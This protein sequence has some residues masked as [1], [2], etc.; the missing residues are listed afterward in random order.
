MKFKIIILA[1]FFSCSLYSQVYSDFVQLS[2]NDTTGTGIGILLSDGTHRYIVRS[3]DSWKQGEKLFYNGSEIYEFKE[4]KS[5]EYHKV[6]VIRIDEHNNFLSLFTFDEPLKT[7]SKFKFIDGE[8]YY[9]A[10]RA[11]GD[12]QI[13]KYTG[14]GKT[15]E[16]FSYT[17]GDRVEFMDYQ[18]R[19]D[20][21][22]V[23]GSFGQ[24]FIEIKGDTI[25]DNGR[26]NIAQ[27]NSIFLYSI[28]MKK[29]SIK[30]FFGYGCYVYYT[31]ISDLQIDK[32]GN[33]VIYGGYYSE[34]MVI[35][36]DTLEYRGGYEGGD[37]YIARLDPNG[38]LISTNFFS[39]ESTH[40]MIE[41]VILSDDGSYYVSFESVYLGELSIDGKIFNKQN[42]LYSYSYFMKF[43]KEGDLQWIDSI[44]IDGG[45][46]TMNAMF[47][48]EGSIYFGGYFYINGKLME[49]NGQKIQH[50]T[51]KKGMSVFFELD[52]KT[53]G[54]NKV[55]DIISNSDEICIIDH[56]QLGDTKSVVFRAFDDSPIILN[57]DTIPMIGSSKKL[58]VNVDFNIDG[59]I[60]Q[61]TS[62]GR[63]ELYPN[64][65]S[66]I[67][68]IKLVD[69]D[70]AIQSYRIYDIQGRQIQAGRL[71]DQS[72]RT[73]DL[74]SGTYVLETKIKDGSR[75]TGKL[76]KL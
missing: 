49:F 38:K 32:N 40:D 17:K 70:N 39:S 72:I 26:N 27:N 9:L 37:G 5:F 75:R 20:E 65:V 33:T 24:K 30:Y 13:R 21:L 64:P 43:N 4:F 50:E 56:I 47:E 73:A 12:F 55:S 57:G 61:N 46:K 28:D 22:I 29:D 36:G 58:L 16:V 15:V 51:E 1:F 54:L 59:V 14:E 35:L 41:N 69:S 68:E 31:I 67:G 3:Y 6:L 74:K 71:Q 34:E 52:K 53:G 66:G 8:L 45:G 60:E 25:W 2:K 11:G 10:R 19:K 63:I 76:I 48:T 42:E 23:M 18:I 7:L 44:N 62:M